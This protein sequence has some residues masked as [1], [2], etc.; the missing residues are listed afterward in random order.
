MRKRVWRGKDQQSLAAD[1]NQNS[2]PTFGKPHELQG[3]QPEN[4]DK[5]VHSTTV[6]KQLK[7]AVFDFLTPGFYSAS[8]QRSPEVR[9][10]VFG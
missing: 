3:N 7:S 8:W 9:R 6:V 10:M 4:C 1:Q 5:P 2:S